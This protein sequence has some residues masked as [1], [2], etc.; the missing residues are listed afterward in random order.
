MIRYPLGAALSLSLGEVVGMAG[1]M[2]SERSIARVDRRPRLGMPHNT[3]DGPWGRPH[4][5]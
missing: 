5:A 4:L 3:V 2:D 1:G